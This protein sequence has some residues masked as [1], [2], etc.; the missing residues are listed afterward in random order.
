MSWEVW[1]LTLDAK[2]VPLPKT[3]LVVGPLIGIRSQPVPEDQVEPG[4]VPVVLPV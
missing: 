1:T 2:A 4:A 3:R